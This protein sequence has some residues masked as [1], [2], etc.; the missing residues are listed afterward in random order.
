[1]YLFYDLSGRIISSSTS[2]S[3][4]DKITYIPEGLTV[5]Y[6][7]DNQHQDII[8]NTPNYTI[9]DGFP[10]YTPISDL[11]KLPFIQ[12]AKIEEIN[13]ACNK[14]ILGG[15]DSLIL[16]ESNHY[17]FDMEYQA[18]MNQQMGILSLDQTIE[19]IP[20]P[21]S[22]GVAIHTKTQFIQLLKEASDF[23]SSKLFRYFDLKQQIMNCQNTYD[24]GLINW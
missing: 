10:I 6:I 4:N 9:V 13:I 14:E 12:Q 15:F 7:D 24:V 22:S 18:N 11:E 20:W 3:S 2:S 5:L 8:K 23:K 21:T 1:M 19:F 17:K 16:G